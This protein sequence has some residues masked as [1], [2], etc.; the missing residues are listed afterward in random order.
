MQIVLENANNRNAEAIRHYAYYILKENN[1]SLNK[2]NLTGYSYFKCMEKK[3]LINELSFSI[4]I[5]ETE[6][7]FNDQ[8]IKIK[9]WEL[10]NPIGDA[11]KQNSFIYAKMIIECDDSDILN[12]FIA[13][14]YIYFNENILNKGKLTNKINIYMYDDNEWYTLSKNKIRNID[15]VYLKK[16]VKENLLQDI[17]TFLKPETEKWYDDRGIP[18]KLNMIF[19]GYPGTGKTS[20]IKSIASELNYNLAMI[21]F[22]SEMTDSKLI[23]SLKEV[24]K[25]T[26]VVLE[27][28]DVLFKARKENDEYRTNLSF[29][30]LLNSLDGA[31]SQNGLIII[32]TTNYL[33]NLDD[34]LTRSGRIDKILEFTYA[35]KYQIK[36][37][38]N[39]FFPNS[40]FNIFYDLIRGNNFTISQ[41]Q[42]Y[43]INNINK[44]NTDNTK[45]IENIDQLLEK[46]HSND[47]RMNLYS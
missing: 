31:V 20:T 4:P 33:C 21:N 34:A 22:D 1:D 18:Y 2:I 39:T 13:E 7:I 8:L 38:Y 10:G 32:M 17:K 25:E 45:V 24:P 29:S 9:I 44:L 47:K 37:I 35:D 41:I 16:D 15:T 28:V 19:H 30:A 3:K 46:S 26:I 6:L 43:F 12:N 23:R 5:G 14:S 42:E 40:D 36:Q 11:G 27:D